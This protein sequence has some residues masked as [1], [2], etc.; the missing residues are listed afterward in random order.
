MRREGKGKAYA[1][2]VRA[3]ALVAE[4]TL[5]DDFAVGVGLF[6]GHNIAGS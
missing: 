3:I 1:G 5:A 6:V 4:G 2:A